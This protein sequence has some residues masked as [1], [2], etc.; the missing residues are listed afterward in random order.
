MAEQFDQDAEQL[1]F[2]D[3]V[4]IRENI[5]PL[6][7]LAKGKVILNATSTLG[8]ALAAFK[9]YMRDRGFTPHT[10]Q[11][12]SQDMFILREY[13][14]PAKSIGDISTA[15]LNAFLKWMERDRGVPCRPKTMERRITTLKVFFGWLAEEGYL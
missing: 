12:F 11:A 10:Q 8:E 3:D 7:A 13:L 9:Q 6:P 2:F 15:T 14:E 5:K 1:T 4:G